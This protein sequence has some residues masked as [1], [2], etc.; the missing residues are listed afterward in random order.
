V[1]SREKIQK[2]SFAIKDSKQRVIREFNAEGTPPKEIIWDGRDANGALAQD[3]SFTYLFAA[4]TIRGHDMR[5]EGLLVAIDSQGPQGV[6][7]GDEE[8]RQ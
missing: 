5:R 6:I 4:K 2:W 7:S 3:G 1:K 8:G